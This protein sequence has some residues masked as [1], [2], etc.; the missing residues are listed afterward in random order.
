MAW[1]STYPSLSATQGRIKAFVLECYLCPT[2]VFFRTKTFL[3]KK[4]F[5]QKLR[6][7]EQMEKEKLCFMIIS[8]QVGQLIKYHL[9]DLRI[10]SLCWKPIDSIES[11]FFVGLMAKAL[12][13]IVCESH[14]VSLLRSYQK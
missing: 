2:Q 4:S 6:E 3:R 8:N 9:L 13:L 1:Q 10:F 14:E 5:L 7:R 11:D 12:L